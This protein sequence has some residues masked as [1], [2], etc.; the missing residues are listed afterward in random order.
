MKFKGM[1]KE[2]SNLNV[3]LSSWKIQK[4]LLLFNMFKNCNPF[5]TRPKWYKNNE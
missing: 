5:Q 4:D 2:Y 1:F 3:N